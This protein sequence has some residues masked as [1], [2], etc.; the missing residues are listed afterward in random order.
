[1]R[2]ADTDFAC[3]APDPRTRRLLPQQIF[4]APRIMSSRDTGMWTPL[5]TSPSVGFCELNRHNE[6]YRHR[7]F[8][9]VWLYCVIPLKEEFLYE[10]TVYFGRSRNACSDYRDGAIIEVLPGH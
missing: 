9:L 8:G 6:R 5:I 1:M 4:E 10:G 2:G 3:R 7:A